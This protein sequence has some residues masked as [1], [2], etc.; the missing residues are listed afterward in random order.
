MVAF[1]SNRSV[2]SIYRVPVLS[3]TVLESLA[4]GTPVVAGSTGISNDLVIDGYNGF[5][6]YP[7]DYKEIA[8]KI[9]MLITD[10]ILWK[11]LSANARSMAT[12]FDA[13]VVAKKYI[14]LYESYCTIS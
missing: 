7:T 8:R 6:V 14:K 10:N 11:Q 5:R 1:R 2:P 12:N 3:P 13:S 9:L 4:S